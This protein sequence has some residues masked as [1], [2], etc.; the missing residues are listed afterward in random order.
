MQSGFVL[1]YQNQLLT[2]I[3]FSLPRSR[4]HFRRQAEKRISQLTP[5]STNVDTNMNLNLLTAVDCVALE[6]LTD[7][8]LSRQGPV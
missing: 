2:K 8:P 5:E 1:Q 3:A 7:M 6:G 4:N